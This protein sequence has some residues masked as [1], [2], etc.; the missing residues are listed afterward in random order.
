[1]DEHVEAAVH[2]PVAHA[3][4]VAVARLDEPH[5]LQPLHALA[6]RRHVHAEVGR[7]R[8]LGREPLTR[9]VAAGQHAGDEPAEHLVGH[10]SSRNLRHGRDQCSSVRNILRRILRQ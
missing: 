7:E 10:G 8:P 2:A 3:H 4:A 1:V 6:D 9:R 5:L